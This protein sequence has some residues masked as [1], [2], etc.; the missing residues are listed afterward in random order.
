MNKSLLRII[1]LGLYLILFLIPGFILIFFRDGWG[2][3][4]SG[5]A[6]LAAYTFVRLFGLY[7]FTLAFFQI[8]IGAFFIDLGKIFGPKTVLLFHRIEGIFVLTLAF[9]HPFFY[10]L[11]NWLQVK[12]LSILQN[13]VP[14]YIGSESERLISFGLTALYLLIVTVITA[15]FRN[16]PILIR[17]WRKIH[18]LNYLIFFLA[19]FH[20]FLLGT[21]TQTLPLKA[22]WV[23][24]LGLG[25]VAFLYRRFLKA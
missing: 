18:Y 17:N 14:N 15:Y 12:N 3:L 11:Y 19:F 20:S 13:L 4:T 23:V 1:I 24:Y 16:S 10:L 7:T 9:T 21:D 8:L 22:F 2:F 25:L 5:S 6:E